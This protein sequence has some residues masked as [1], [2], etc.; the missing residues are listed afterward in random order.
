VRRE[1]QAYAAAAAHIGRLA[2]VLAAAAAADG[3]AAKLMYVS[4]GWQQGQACA[5]CN[6][7]NVH[8]FQGQFLCISWP[9]VPGQHSG[10]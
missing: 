8:C 9:D 3:A 2:S 4:V 10:T 1:E 6:T 5:R 7:N